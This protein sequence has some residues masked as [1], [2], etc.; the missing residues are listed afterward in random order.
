MNDC[1]NSRGTFVWFF[2]HTCAGLG[3]ESLC[4]VV[5]STTINLIQRLFDL[6]LMV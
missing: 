3:I 2:I 1:G 6:A 5:I 4:D